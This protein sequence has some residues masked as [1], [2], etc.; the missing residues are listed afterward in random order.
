MEIIKKIIC[1]IFRHDLPAL[2]YNEFL[3]GEKL[4]KYVCCRRCGKQIKPVWYAEYG[5]CILAP[6]KKIRIES[7]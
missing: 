3:T 7:R 4:K 6:T 2:N 5:F 1:K